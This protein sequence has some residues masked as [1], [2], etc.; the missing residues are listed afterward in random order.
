MRT[1]SSPCGRHRSCPALPDDGP[2]EERSIAALIARHLPA[3]A[4]VV[5]EALTVGRD[6][7]AATRGAPPHDWLEVCGGSIGGGFPLATG[8][9]IA[10]PDRKV[11][12]LEG[13]GSGMYTVQ[14]LWTQARERLDIVTLVFA[15]RRYAILEHELDNV[16]ADSGETARR[17]LAL[18][19]P[20]LDWVALA[21]GMGVDGVRVASVNELDEALRRAMAGAGPFLVE[22]LV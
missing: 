19:D 1:R 5:D 15:N 8:A 22:V 21:R 10:C 2:L 16:Q 7:L 14:A 12:C 13:D 3:R 17:M 18:D 6:F 9:A 20:S 11:V 4:I